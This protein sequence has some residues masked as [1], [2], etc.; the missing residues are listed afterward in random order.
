MPSVAEMCMNFEALTNDAKYHILLMHL[1][2]YHQFLQKYEFHKNLVFLY[3]SKIY[4]DNHLKN[5]A[6]NICY[7]HARNFYRFI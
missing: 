2:Y 7:F 6:D 4:I 3:Y 1:F 5:L